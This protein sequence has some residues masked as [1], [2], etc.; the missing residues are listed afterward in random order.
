VIR[1]LNRTPWC[2]NTVVA[3]AQHRELLDQ[4]LAQFGI[5]VDI[6]LGIM[7]SGQ[8]L[9]LLTARLCEGLD[10]V[11]TARRPHMIVAQGDTTTVMI[12]AL[13]AFYR[14]IPFAHV[15][16]GLRT[17]N[18]ANP[19]PEEL[20]RTIT[21]RIAALNFAPTDTARAALLREGVSPERVFVTG[22]TIVDA[23]LETAATRPALPLPID[24]GQQ[25]V[26]LTVHRRE[27][28]G[29]PLARIFRSV[30]AL[31]QRHPGVE[32]IY[33]IHPN[34]EVRA[35][36]TQMLAGKSRIHMIEPLDYPSLVAVLQRASFLLT[37]SGGLQEEAPIVG[38]PVLVLRDET[39]RPEGRRRRNRETGRNRR[40]RDLD[41]GV[42]AGRGHHVLRSDG[43][44]RLAL[45]RRASRRAHRRHI[46]TLRCGRSRDL[47]G[48]ER[49]AEA[50]PDPVAIW[51]HR[52]TCSDPSRL[53]RARE[54]FQEKWKPAFRPKMRSMQK[55][56]ACSV[57]IELNML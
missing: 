4:V 33:P 47:S 42:P 1:L 13:A 14:R 28:L 18:F 23:F 30:L 22:N 50:R 9:A 7:T 41:R 8:S 21:G 55:A 53:F 25:L 15:E 35:I 46:A 5:A 26:L 19:F 31:I 38:K 32:I 34:P 36:A 3:T 48:D 49:A 40:G 54:H 45:W 52:S 16:A 29:A 17:G 10:P 56:R 44:T 11:L 43:A 12:A 20:N 57:S 27:N 24:A 39:E 2:E 51:R 37:D 6:D